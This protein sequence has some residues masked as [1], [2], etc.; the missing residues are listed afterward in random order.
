MRLRRGAWILGLGVV[1]VGAGVVSNASPYLLP[2]LG[3]MA[4]PAVCTHGSQTFTYTGSNQTFTVPAGC[5]SLTVKAWGTTRE[6][7]AES[8]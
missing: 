4:K 6:Q 7:T 8:F 1:A 3:L 2:Q 5:T